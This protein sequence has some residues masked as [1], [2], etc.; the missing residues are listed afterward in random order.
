MIE[1]SI[2]L[3][4][5][6]EITIQIENPL[7]ILQKI[8]GR[9][10]KSLCDSVYILQTVQYFDNF[11]WSALVIAARVS[12]KLSQK[13]FLLPNYHLAKFRPEILKSKNWLRPAPLL[14]PGLK[15]IFL[16][17]MDFKFVPKLSKTQWYLYLNFQTNQTKN[18]KW[19]RKIKTKIVSILTTV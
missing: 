11:G 19:E 16:L 1:S 2:V 9:S 15:Q 18:N 12:L 13:Y 7:M 5:D 6:F 3:I 8:W 10:Q 17:W 4:D 14:D